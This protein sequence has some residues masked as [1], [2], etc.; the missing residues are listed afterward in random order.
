MYAHIYE[1]LY[2]IVVEALGSP[3]NFPTSTDTNR[4]VCALKTLHFV[5]LPPE[6]IVLT[7]QLHVQDC[8]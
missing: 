1:H 3:L 2:I 6:S 4:S 5:P 8:I 7:S